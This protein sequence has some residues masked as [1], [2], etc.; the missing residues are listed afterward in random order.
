MQRPSSL[1]NKITMNR[2]GGVVGG[3]L[4]HSIADSNF[5]VT[6]GSI[7]PSVKD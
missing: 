6:A 2:T 3:G 4:M 1:V 7:L 5:G